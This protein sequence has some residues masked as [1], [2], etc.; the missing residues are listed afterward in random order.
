MPN[1]KTILTD[2]EVKD[3]LKKNKERAAKRGGHGLEI[4]TEQDIEEEQAEE[5]CEL[6]SYMIREFTIH[7]L[8]SIHFLQNMEQI[9][10]QEV[11]DRQV[12]LPLEKKHL[13]IH[14]LLLFDLDETLAHCV[15]QDEN[16]D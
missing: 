9:D 13:G 12:D 5:Y 2:Y 7:I 14:K 11:I 3:R 6:Q 15:R 8:Q 1:S 4:A 10:I 16:S